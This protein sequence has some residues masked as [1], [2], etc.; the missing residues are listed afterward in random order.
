MMRIE[1]RTALVIS[2]VELL[3][4]VRSDGAIAQRHTGLSSD[5]QSADKLCDDL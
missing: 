4:Q 5:Y 1:R 2:R 3:R